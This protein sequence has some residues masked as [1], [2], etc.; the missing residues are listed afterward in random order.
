MFLTAQNAI[1]Q[2]ELSANEL[3]N[4]S[5]SFHD[6]NGAWSAFND[7]LE[8]ELTIPNSSKRH[9][10]V[11]INIPEEHFT[12]EVKKD[13]DAYVYE[14][15]KGTCKILFNGSTE[16]SEEDKKTHRLSCER[17]NMM[18]DYYTYLYGLPMKL[19]DPGAI[20]S[21]EVS[22]RVFQG[23]EYLVLKVSYQE[24]VGSD[25]WYFY[26]DPKSYAMEVYQFYHDEAKNDGEYIL[27]TD[28]VEIGGIK[29]PKTR[30][31]YYNSDQKYLGTDKLV[32]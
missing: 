6:P 25:V 21:P 5:I 19:K 7:T 17:G 28:L 13:S 24:E 23:K 16:I 9:S 1:A 10:S 15:D 18:K 22:K 27:L 12:L 26:F 3:L 14:L 29:M 20:L 30:K 4:R 32:N 31:W 2:K 11:Y 8:I